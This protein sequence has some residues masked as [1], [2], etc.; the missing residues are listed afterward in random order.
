M[1]AVLEKPL[2]NALD[3]PRKPEEIAEEE[4]QIYNS[5]DDI[6]MVIPKT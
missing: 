1:P 6:M 4:V 3:P 5:D 2:G